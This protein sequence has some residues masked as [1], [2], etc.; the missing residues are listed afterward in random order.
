MAGRAPNATE[1]LPAAVELLLTGERGQL[2]EVIA[3][4]NDFKMWTV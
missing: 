1:E 3:D 4:S 2:A